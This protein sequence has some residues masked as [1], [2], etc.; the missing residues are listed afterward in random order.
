MED[1]THNNKAVLM[2]IKFENGYFIEYKVA[3][4]WDKVIVDSFHSLMANG[5]I[6]NLYQHS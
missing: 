6:R 4:D 3:N 1:H 5:I 2:N